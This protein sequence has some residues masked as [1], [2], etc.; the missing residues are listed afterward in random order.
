MHLICASHK[1]IPTGEEVLGYLIYRFQISDG[2]VENGI[3]MPGES[4]ELLT[5]LRCDR[6]TSEAR[7][8][9]INRGS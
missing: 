3:Q 8:E 1:V 9:E 4:S 7:I 5:I 6:S 2:R